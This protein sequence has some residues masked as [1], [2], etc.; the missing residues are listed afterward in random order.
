MVTLLASKLGSLGHEIQTFIPLNLYTLTLIIPNTSILSR[1]AYIQSA[2]TNY[3]T[4][5]VK[6]INKIL[7]II[8]NTH[9]F[10]AVT[11]DLSGGG[12]Q[13]VLKLTLVFKT[14]STTYERLF[15]TLLFTGYIDKKTKQPQKKLWVQRAINNFRTLFSRDREVTFYIRDEEISFCSNF[16]HL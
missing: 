1:Y 2:M 10:D 7:K 16:E 13:S 5:L 8:C 14:K 4:S 15:N 12:K 11:F 9:K 6:D 3:T